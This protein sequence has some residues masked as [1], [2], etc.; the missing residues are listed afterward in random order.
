[1][2]TDT[3]QAD[4][5]AGPERPESLVLATTEQSRMGV[6]ERGRLHGPP[7]GDPALT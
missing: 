4:G 5:T 1:M 3:G 2:H 6:D 7:R